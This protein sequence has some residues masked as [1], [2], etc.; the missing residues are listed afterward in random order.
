MVVVLCF[1]CLRLA[2]IWRCACGHG[3][4]AGFPPGWTT[5]LWTERMT[6]TPFFA[7]HCLQGWQGRAWLGLEWHGVA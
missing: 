6:D 5:R 7:W 4:I 3:L 1:A 2:M